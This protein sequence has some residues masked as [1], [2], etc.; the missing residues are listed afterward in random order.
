LNKK[1]TTLGLLIALVILS[2]CLVSKKTIVNHGGGALVGSFSCRKCH[3]QIYDSYIKTAH[4]HSS[5][6]ATKHT[7]KGSFRKGE[8]DFFYS[9]TQKIIMEQRDDTLWQS[10]L[11]NDRIKETHPFDIVIGSG[12]KGQTYL[13]WENDALWQLPISYFSSAHGWV[14]SPGYDMDTINFRRPIGAACLECHAT[15]LQTINGKAFQRGEDRFIRS[16]TVLTIACERCHGKAREHVRYHEQHPSIKEAHF[17]TSFK[18]LS[19]Q[20][21][22]DVCG[23]CHSGGRISSQPAFSYQIGAS[24][25]NFAPPI[26]ILDSSKIDVHGNQ[27]A[28]LEQ[29]KCFQKSI[30]MDCSSCHNT[31]R[32][33]RNLVKFS[34]KCRDCHQQSHVPSCPVGSTNSTATTCVDCHMPKQASQIITVQSNLEHKSIA[35]MVRT[36]LIKVYP[37]KQMP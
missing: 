19:R 30:T 11:I 34:T 16:E 27:V 37:A 21:R 31:H 32:E 13:Y 15:W 10:A 7:V 35:A 20:Q 22:L 23:Q 9:P 12:R 29:S 36:H 6:N 25:N 1:K 5:D 2:Q 17:I 3:T 28:M 26:P 24:L 14:N 18:T 8:N 33:E 4:Y